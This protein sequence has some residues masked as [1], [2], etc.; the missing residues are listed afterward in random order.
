V[1]DAGVYTLAEYYS[2]LLPCCNEVMDAEVQAL[3]GHCPG[4]ESVKPM[5][6]SK[7]T[8]AGVQAMAGHYPGLKSMGLWRCFAVTDAGVKTLAE[9][10]HAPRRRF[11]YWEL[12]QSSLRLCL[13]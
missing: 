8:D 3:A 11:S 12:M 6:C 10:C 4:L 1:T 2:C 13:S 5:R 9:H 7:V